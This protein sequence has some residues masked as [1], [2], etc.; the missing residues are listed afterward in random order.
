[1][2]LHQRVAAKLSIVR[3]YLK[4]YFCCFRNGTEIKRLTKGRNKFYKEFDI[5]RMIRSARKA[6][7]LFD[8]YLSQAQRVLF[9]RAE[10]FTIPRIEESSNSAFKE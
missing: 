10:D 2:V 6:D 3:E 8:L 7:L 1:M 5:I 4:Y 9:W